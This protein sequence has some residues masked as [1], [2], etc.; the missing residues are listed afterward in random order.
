LGGW[1]NKFISLGGRI[2]LLNSV[3]NAIPIFYLSYLKILISVWKKIR[4]LQREFLWGGRGGRKKLCWVKWDAV[5]QPKR[6][7]GLGVKDIRAVNISL[8]AK[9]RWRLLNDDK[10]LWK[11]VIRSKYGDSVIGRVEWGEGSKL[12]FSSSWWRDICSIGTNLDHNWS[13]GWETVSKLVFGRMSGLVILRCV[14]V[15]PVC[16]LFLNNRKRQWLV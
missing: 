3:L 16:F 13:K 14:L 4:R 10:A 5:C 9:W 7:G 15:S 6:W 11:E 2:T 8:L 1:A 12:W